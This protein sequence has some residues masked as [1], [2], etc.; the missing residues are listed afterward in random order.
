[1]L[2]GLDD[3]VVPGAA[4]QVSGDRLADLELARVL[5]PLEER[6]AGDHHAGRAEAALQRVLLGE[7]FLDRMELAALLQALDGRDLAAVGL[8]REHGAGFD[9]LAVQH[10]GAHAAV[11]RVAA[12]VRAGEA[13]ILADEMHEQEARFDFRLA[14][15][16]VHRD[17]DLVLRHDYCPPARCSALRKARVASTRVISRLYSTE[18]RRSALGEPAFAARRA[19]SAMLFSFKAFPERIF[20]AS[21]AS[22]GVG[23]TLVRPMPARSTAPFLSSVSCTATATAAKSPVLR[24]SFS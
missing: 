5:V 6:A 7:A 8:H 15:R 3:V 19:A 9:R 2:H 16:A 12:D 14:H 10:H 1:M 18:P 17:A 22:N 20:M 11:R 24:L 13:E 4:A 21:T 23:A